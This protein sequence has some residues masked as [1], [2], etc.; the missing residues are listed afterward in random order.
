MIINYP[1]P[2]ELLILIRKY[3]IDKYAFNQAL[4]LQ[5]DKLK[6]KLN[7]I[8]LE[9]FEVKYYTTLTIYDLLL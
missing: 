3:L 8:L 9:P 1:I 4:C 6:S 2:V 5:P 7:L